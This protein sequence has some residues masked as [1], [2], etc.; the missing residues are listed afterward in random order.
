MKLVPHYSL[1]IYT[2]PLHF[3]LTIDPEK[4]TTATS[5]NHLGQFRIVKV[6][7]DDWS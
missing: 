3:S 6:A 2:N 1:A 4:G 5:I 7:G